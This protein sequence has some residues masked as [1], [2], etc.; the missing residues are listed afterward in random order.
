M[1]PR[2]DDHGT[3][4][5]PERSASAPVVASPGSAPVTTGRKKAAWAGIDSAHSVAAEVMG[6]LLVWAGIGWLLD[7]WLGTTPWFLAI[8]AL[9]GNAAAVWMMY[10]RSLRAEQ[11]DLRASRTSGALVPPLQPRGERP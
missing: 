4:A 7:R 11:A 8:G 10:Q 3:D 9:V 1:A 5:A 6:A 2:P